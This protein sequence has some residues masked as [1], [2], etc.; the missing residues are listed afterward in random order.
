MSKTDIT[1]VGVGNIGAAIVKKWLEKGFTV[2][3][4]NRNP[5]RPWLKDLSN[6]GAIFE[7]DLKAAIANSD[8]IFLSVAAYSNITEFF[9]PI[10]PV[11]KGQP[12]KTIINITTGT[13]QQAREM[14]AWLKAH[15]VAEY[16]DGAIMVTPELVGTEHSSIWLSGETEATFSKISSIMSPIG[17]SH[18]VAEDPGAASLWDIAA[19]AA[20]DGMLTG[21][22]LAMNLLRRQREARDGKAPSVEN[23]IRAIV[24]PLLSS[25]LPFLGDIAA[26][27]DDEDWGRN[28][29]NPVSM[30]L[31]GFE[32]ILEGLR[33]EKVSTESLQLFH[34]LL[35][36]TKREK[37]DDAGLAPMGMYMLEE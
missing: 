7:H 9:S 32:T 10:L 35:L 12:P 30:Q 15:G 33:Q 16:L 17:Q 20:M 14:E 27:L 31:K 1:I 6:L 28:F 29:G 37:G 24:I 22:I 25:F 4:W 2:T 36:R 18:Y 19:L 21:G 3:M 23:P 34:N 5:D 26:A 13:P 8:V 11:K